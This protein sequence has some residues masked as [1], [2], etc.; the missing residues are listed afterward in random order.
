MFAMSEEE[1]RQFHLVAAACTLGDLYLHR[2]ESKV[3]GQ[4]DGILCEGDQPNRIFHGF[5]RETARQS[6]SIPALIDLPEIF[7]DILRQANPPGDPLRDLTM[8][9][10]DRNIDLRALG[11]A[12]FDR[13]GQFVGRCAGKLSGNGADED[14]D[15]FGSVTDI[16]MMKLP[17]QGDFVAPRSASRWVSALH[18]M[19]RSS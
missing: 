7:P 14:L 12:T 16:D 9:G 5:T 4:R 13:L 1:F 10:Q 11:K 2:F 18:P 8:A 6:L 17:A 15:E 3:V 19:Y